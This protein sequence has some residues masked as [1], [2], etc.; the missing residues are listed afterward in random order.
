MKRQQQIY[1]QGFRI[2]FSFLFLPFLIFMACK[3]D[4]YASYRQQYE[5]ELQDEVPHYQFVSFE[6]IE[7]YTVADSL[8]NE[9]S[10]IQKL[11]ERYATE[12]DHEMHKQRSV[13]ITEQDQQTYRKTKE[14]LKSM[15]HYDSLKREL[16]GQIDG[17]TQKENRTLE[18][19]AIHSYKSEGTTK[20][21]LVRFNADD[22]VVSWGKSANA[23]VE[24]RHN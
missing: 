6:F 5:A 15:R 1:P 3:H 14:L 11:Y 12:F 18:K 4:E 8:R 19:I 13:F 21:I 17:L 9:L 23:T 10:G 22:Q 16:Q 20:K 24:S 7:P 2:R